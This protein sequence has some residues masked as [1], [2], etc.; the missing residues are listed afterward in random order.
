MNT[1]KRTIVFIICLF[2][3]LAFA[4]VYIFSELYTES[5]ISEATITDAKI[6][7]EE[8]EKVNGVKGENGKVV[9]TLDIPLDNP[10]IYKTPDELVQALKNKETFVVY[11]GFSECPWCR[12]IL[13]ELMVSAKES[14]LKEIYYVDIKDIRDTYVLD[15]E[16]NPVI[17][18]KGTDA[19]YDLLELLNPVLE[20]YNPLVYTT[21]KGKVKKVKVPSKRI[22]A[23]NIIVVRN[24]EP[25]I[26]IDGI[27]EDLADPYQELTKEIRDSIIKE[28]KD[29]FVLLKEVEAPVCKDEK[30]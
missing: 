18:V 22:Y 5:E 25:M 12:S 4:I 10:F 6:F 20:D 17:D 14:Y 29:A 8:Y 27:T 16:N 9:R 15:E 7:K 3:F 24:G 30:C 26:N 1:K 19:Y 21:K 13:N 2:L 28:F 23:P 11:F